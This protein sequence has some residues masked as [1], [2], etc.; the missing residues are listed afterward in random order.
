MRNNI[1][2][3]PEYGAPHPGRVKLVQ[4]EIFG[5][6]LARD[7]IDELS[8]QIAIGLVITKLLTGG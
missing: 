2:G 5:K 4:L 1:S 6:W 7:F 3:I 8:K